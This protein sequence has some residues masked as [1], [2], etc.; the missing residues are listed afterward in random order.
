MT[1]F[2]SRS[3]GD[4]PRFPGLPPVRRIWAF[5]LGGTHFRAS[6]A[7]IDSSDSAQGKMTMVVFRLSVDLLCFVREVAY[8]SDGYGLASDYGEG[9]K[10]KRLTKDASPILDKHCYDSYEWHLI[11]FHFVGGEKNVTLNPSLKPWK[12]IRLIYVYQKRGL[13]Q[14]IILIIEILHPFCLV[15]FNATLSAADYCQLVNW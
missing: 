7:K 13:H 6:L 5:S 4:K 1:S 8:L 10:K 9:L 14:Y 12:L 2:V 11:R 15:F 3:A